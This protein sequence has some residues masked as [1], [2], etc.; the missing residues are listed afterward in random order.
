MAA[1]TIA[2]GLGGCPPGNSGLAIAS[3]AATPALLTTDSVA[4]GGT[5]NTQIIPL[6]TWIQSPGQ[7]QLGA[8]VR[9]DLLGPP[10]SPVVLF[11]GARRAHLVIPGIPGHVLLDFTVV[12]SLPLILLDAQGRFA[13]TVSVPLDPALRHLH[14]FFQ[15]VAFPP[16]QLPTITNLGDLRLR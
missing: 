1:S 9:L 3:R 15:G 16:A 12:R 2:G 14:V 7:A 13:L 4:T 5:L 11:L 10:G 8:P 6:V